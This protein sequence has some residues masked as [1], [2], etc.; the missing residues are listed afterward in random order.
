MKARRGQ[1]ELPRLTV[2]SWEASSAT[3]VVEAVVTS[4]SATV[5]CRTVGAFNCLAAICIDTGVGMGIPRADR[6]GTWDPDAEAFAPG[7][8][9]PA[10]SATGALVPCMG[11]GLAIGWPTD[12]LM[13]SVA[14][15]AW[16]AADV[17]AFFNIA[18]LAAAVWL[19][20]AVGMPP[21]WWG[22]L[23]A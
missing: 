12:G 16:L 10:S 11:A 9:E 13:G 4:R 8:M 7:I 23:A 14:G 19:A 21:P 17:A 20:D 6:D 18:L 5:E 2:L 1:S 22:L 3:G 15:E